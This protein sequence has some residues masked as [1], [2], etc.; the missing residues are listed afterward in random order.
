MTKKALLPNCTRFTRAKE[1]CSSLSQTKMKRFTNKIAL[2][3]GAG[4]GIGYEIAKQL[5]AEGAKVVLND[6]DEKVAQTAVDTLQKEHQNSCIAYAGDAS[7]VDFI[8]E[9]VDFVVKTYGQLDMV[10]ANAGTTVFGNFLDFTPESFQKV[11]NLNLKGTFFLVQAF[12]KHAQKQE[13]SG[14]I[15]LMSSVIGIQSYP[16]LAAYSMSKAGIQMLARTLVA[17][18]SPLSIRINA[19]APGATLTERT[20][21]EETDYWDTWSKI[22]PLNQ[23]ATPNDIAKTTLFLLSDDAQHITGQTIV[24]DGGWTVT[25]MRPK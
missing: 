6:W 1:G 17:E 14:S 2:I 12:A 20:A 10:I 5:V 8:Y 25:G 4:T 21:V 7:D 16:N 9:M 19:I 18:L 22:T 23:I 3:T 11:V 24:V 15:V 13:T